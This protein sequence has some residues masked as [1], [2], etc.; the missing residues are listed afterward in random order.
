MDTSPVK[1]PSPSSEAD[2]ASEVEMVVTVIVPGL[3]GSQAR[4]VRVMLVVDPSPIPMISASIS[5]E[6]YWYCELWP[7]RADRLV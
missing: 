3:I 5:S 7:V 1:P 6:V 4:L 2:K